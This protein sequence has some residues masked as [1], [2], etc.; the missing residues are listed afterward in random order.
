MDKVI[1]SEGMFLRPQHFQQFERYIE[2][3]VVSRNR[4]FTPYYWGVK[5]LEFDLSLLSVG[6]VAVVFAEGVFPDGSLFNVNYDPDFPLVIQVTKGQENQCLYLAIPAQINGAVASD[7]SA[8]SQGVRYR[9]KHQDIRD[10]HGVDNDRVYAIATGDLNVRL[11]TED[12]LEDAFIALPIA[13]INAV[14]VD[15]SVVLNSLFGAPA[16]DMS[17]H[18]ECMTRLTDLVILMHEKAKQLAST[19]ESGK[20]NGA[21][22][23]VDLL[24]LKALNSWGAE[25]TI[26]T[27]QS[28]LHPYKLFKRLSMFVAEISTFARAERVAVIGVE[29]SHIASSQK[30]QALIENARVLVS[31]A[32]KSKAVALPVQRKKFG[33][34][35]VGLPTESMVNDEFILAIKADLSADAI[36]K[37][38]SSKLKAGSIDNIKDLVNLQL[39]G[40]V[41][42]LLPVTP[43]QIPYH[44]GMHYFRLLPDAEMKGRIKHSNGVGLHVSGDVPGMELEFWVVS[45]E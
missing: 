40:C 16:I 6:K 18:A 39:P 22:T 19:I 41:K 4:Y 30:L 34:S 23:V 43:R 7:E 8:H 25:L 29:Y 10:S 17:I 20:G 14:S 11:L 38:V 31:T 3:Q 13:Q 45:A 21:G 2:D 33:I 42:E 44:A 26:L 12:Q 36:R 5:T 37:L 35:V 27:Q 15:G 1:W 28:P 9:Q 32:F 24:M